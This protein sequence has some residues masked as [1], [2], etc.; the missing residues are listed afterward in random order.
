MI[1]KDSVSEREYLAIPNIFSLNVVLF[2]KLKNVT[3]NMRHD[4]LDI[5]T[6]GDITI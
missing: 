1:F 3:K 6:V 4:S 2:N 5:F